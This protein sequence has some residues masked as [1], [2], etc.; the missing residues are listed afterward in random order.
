MVLVA[1]A[2][3]RHPAPAAVVA[4]APPTCIHPAAPSIRSTLYFGMR[5]AHGGEVSAPEW[6]EFLAREVTP[7]VGGLTVL[8]ARGQWL[9]SDGPLV[10]EE[11]RVV[12]ILHADTESPRAAIAQVIRRYR[13]RF[14]QESVLWET[15][16]VCV[17]Y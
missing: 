3:V 7:R 16:P 13:E 15:A 1:C 14:D 9:G 2:P 6:E 5:R 12:V 17:T 10:R 8:Q 4:A 11:S